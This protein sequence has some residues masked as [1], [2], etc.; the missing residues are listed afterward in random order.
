[1]PHWVDIAQ[2]LELVTPDAPIGLKPMLRQAVDEIRRLREE[3]RIEREWPTIKTYMGVTLDELWRVY[4]EQQRW[5]EA[6]IPGGIQFKD[7]KAFR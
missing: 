2:S 5:R 4:N 3:R 7:W 1:M 6:N